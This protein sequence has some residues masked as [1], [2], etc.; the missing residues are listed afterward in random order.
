MWQSRQDHL[1]TDAEDRKIREAN[2]HWVVPPSQQYMIVPF[3]VEV[4]GAMGDR[5]RNFL[6]VISHVRGTTSS[7]S[8]NSS[9]PSGP[10]GLH[11]A[12]RT[13]MEGRNARE[14]AIWRVKQC[15]AAA[16]HRQNAWDVQS[17]VCTAVFSSSPGPMK[18][19]SV[20]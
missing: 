15:I 10:S 19:G 14:S 12:E 2:Q 8:S 4:T 6:R 20:T 5:V 9:S 17:Y 16:E 7:N 11:G 3:V 13:E 1:C 18:P